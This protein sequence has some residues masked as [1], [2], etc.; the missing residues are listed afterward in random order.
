MG[1]GMLPGRRCQVGEGALPLGYPESRQRSELRRLAA[2]FQG[3][4]VGGGMGVATVW[5][6]LWAWLWCG[7]GFC[8]GGAVGQ[9]LSRTV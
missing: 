2:D 5:V 9:V 3:G 7:R 4:V 8:V 6:G 1:E